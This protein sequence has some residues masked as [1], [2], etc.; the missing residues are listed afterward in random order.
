M[1]QANRKPYLSNTQIELACKCPEAYRRRYIERD[2]I[3]PGI[4]LMR[5]IGFHTGA[6]VNLRQ[7]MKTHVDLPANEVVDAAVAEFEA[8]IAGGYMLTAEEASRGSTVV[9]GEAKDSLAKLSTCHAE[10]Q[11]PEYQP[12]LVE[13]RIELSLPGPRNLLGV[14]DLADERGVVTDFKTAKRSRN[15]NDAHDSVQLSIYA[16]AYEA[17]YGKPPAEVRLDVLVDLKKETK[18]QVLQ[19]TRSKDDLVAL[20]NRVNTVAKLVE[21]GIYAPATSGAWWC[22]DKWCGYYRTCPYI[23]PTRAIEAELIRQKQADVLLECAEEI[24]ADISVD[25]VQLDIKTVGSTVVGEIDIATHEA[26]RAKRPKPKTKKTLRDR[27]WEWQEG[28]CR[29]CNRQVRKNEATLD[30]IVP[31]AMGGASDVSNCCVACEECNRERADT[32]LDPKH[33]RGDEDG[34][35]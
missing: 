5:G 30:H 20:A 7:K 26:Q 18:R 14:L 6:K 1:T 24:D 22:S 32:G 27:L 19:S 35:C 25:L 11:A 15:Q 23:N 8:S 28:R 31:V 12:I 33:I 21:A 3:P 17:K 13:E 2:V 34:D 4:A 10:K 16:A 9:V 29:W